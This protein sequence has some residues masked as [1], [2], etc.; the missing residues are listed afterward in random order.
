MPILL[1]NEADAII[2]K[3]KNA[4]ST[5]VADTEKCNSKY[6]VRRAGKLQWNPICNIQFSQ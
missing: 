1:F 5:S 3:R 6:I 2:G 4:G